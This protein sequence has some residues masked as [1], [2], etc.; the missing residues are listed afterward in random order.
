MVEGFQK[1]SIE[2]YHL[3]LDT[4]SCVLA[5]GVLSESYLDFTARSAFIK[6]KRSRVRS[7]RR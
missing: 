7:G 6:E 3:E 1:T 2:Y 4:H 5:N